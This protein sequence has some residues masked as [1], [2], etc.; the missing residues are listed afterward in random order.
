[1]NWEK[2]YE[3]LRDRGKTWGPG[4]DDVEEPSEEEIARQDALMV[5]YR[6]KLKAYSVE[7]R[8]EFV[9]AGKELKASIPG[10]YDYWREDYHKKKISLCQD[11]CKS[12]GYS[13]ELGWVRNHLDANLE[14][15]TFSISV[16][17]YG[18]LPDRGGNIHKFFV[19]GIDDV[20]DCLQLVADFSAIGATPTTWYGE[21][22]HYT[23][24]N[25]GEVRNE[26]IRRYG[27]GEI[28]VSSSGQCLQHE[29][30]D[31]VI[32]DAEARVEKVSSAGID[33]DIE[34]D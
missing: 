5:A 16:E 17:Y 20:E 27:I 34:K 14:R 9:E 22:F 15:N 28:D 12:L 26:L 11:A 24:G 31:S 8:K 33:K 25:T 10:Q 4:V 19:C 18:W 32:A 7:P 30:I 3:H 2:E 13:M 29:S 23:S 21:N 6:E 1:M